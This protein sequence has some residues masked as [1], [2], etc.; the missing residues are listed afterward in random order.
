MPPKLLPFIVPRKPNIDLRLR[1]QQIARKRMTLVS[2]LSGHEGIAF[3]ADTQ[4]TV[5]GY[6]KKVMDK[7]EVWDF[8]GRPFRFVL[9]G[10]SDDGDYS[11]MLQSDI[12]STLLTL[13]VFDL[14]RIKLALTDTLTEFYGKHFGSR[15]AS[16]RPRL[17]YLIAIQPLPTGTPEIV[18]VVHSAVNF[19]GITAHNKSIGIGSYLADYL[20]GR[21]LGGGEPFVQLCAAAVY[22]AREV[23]ENVDGVGQMDRI[24]LFD[25][26]G[27]YDELVPIDIE[28]IEENLGGINEGILHLFSLCSDI[29]QG[30]EQYGLE[31]TITG[32]GQEARERHKQ[33]FSEW[34]GRVKSRTHYL[35]VLNW[36]IK[37]KKKA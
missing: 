30:S 12:S 3:F 21:I 13:D 32:I 33:W 8:P 22:V 29:S 7:V 2:A 6:S 9:A 15:P 5:A 28:T 14:G 19:L 16:E 24:V 17:E 10:S 25:R 18:H 27:G 11:D 4:E 31:E 35:D 1:Q 34:Q 26:T 36:R 37:A 23:R 20:Y